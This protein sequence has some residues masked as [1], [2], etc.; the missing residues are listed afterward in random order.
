VN[1]GGTYREEE[2]MKKLMIAVAIGVAVKVLSDL[3][4]ANL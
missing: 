4:E 3:I 1:P 2:A